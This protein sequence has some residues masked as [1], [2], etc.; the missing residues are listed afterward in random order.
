MDRT[1]TCWFRLPP[2]YHDIDPK[3]LGDVDSRLERELPLIHEDT[4]AGERA[5]RKTHALCGLLAAMHEQGTMHAS[6]GLH[7]GQNGELCVSLVT[8][9][10]VPT[11]APN[12]ALAAALSGIELATG[13]FGTVLDRRLVDLACGRPAALAARIL[14]DLPAGLRT[15]AG[16][17]AEPP[18]VFQARLAVAR[19]N[20]SRVVV[21][22]LTTCATTMAAEYTDILVG[23]G[24]SVSFVEPDPKPAAQLRPSRLLELLS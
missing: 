12:A 2:G 11:G 1:D 17:E 23:I 13:G 3:G 21:I 8:V 6:F 7:H 10:D 15:A 24:Q 5:L 19:P 4:A 9:S 16:I 18:G 22:D 14:P 20:G